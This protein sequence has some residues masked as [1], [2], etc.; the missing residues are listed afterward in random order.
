MAITKAIAIIETGDSLDCSKIG[1]SG[2]RGCHQFLPSTW[3]AYSSIVLGY[4]A[5]QTPENAEHVT[6]E[7]IARWISQ[8]YTDRQ[9]FL[10]WNQGNTGQCKS[11][12]NKYGVKYDS[13]AYVEKA[14]QVL[15]KVTH[16]S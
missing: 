8:G 5:D 1:L 2:E 12:V 13:C 6:H 15:E 16:S 14:L 3:E 11:G 10:I 9:I 4:V 7:M